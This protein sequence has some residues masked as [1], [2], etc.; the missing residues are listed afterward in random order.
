MVRTNAV[1]SDVGILGKG[2]F[3]LFITYGYSKITSREDNIKKLKNLK[4]VMFFI[5]GQA[6]GSGIKF[7][8]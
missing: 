8:E 2:D 4:D 3:R 1:K 6:R 7:S 5:Q